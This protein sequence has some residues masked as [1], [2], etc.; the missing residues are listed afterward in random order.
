MRWAG[1]VLFRDAPRDQELLG[2]VVYVKDDA[3]NVRGYYQAGPHR[4]GNPD[5][6]AI[7]ML[8][9]SIEISTL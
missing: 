9:T 7:E 4:V 2:A 6:L 3:G 1:L 5:P 8:G